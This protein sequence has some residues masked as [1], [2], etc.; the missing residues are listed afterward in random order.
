MLEIIM[1]GSKNKVPIWC[2]HIYRCKIS[3]SFEGIGDRGLKYA[4]KANYFWPPLALKTLQGHNVDS[5]FYNHFLGPPN[6][7]LGKTKKSSFYAVHWEWNLLK[8]TSIIKKIG[9]VFFFFSISKMQGK[10][11][12]RTNKSDFIHW[13][14]S[15]L[16]S[17]LLKM[18][19]QS[20]VTELP[21]FLCTSSLFSLILLFYTCFEATLH[22][23][24]VCDHDSHQNRLLSL[25]RVGS[26]LHAC[27]TVF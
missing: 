27:D 16:P 11:Q 18:Q 10:V 4:T 15:I 26:L 22:W 17:S 3:K 23:L 5:T 21:N 25:F 2:C 1:K 14:L 8:N 13:R 20:L 24:W 9:K 19:G 6:F 12:A 7:P